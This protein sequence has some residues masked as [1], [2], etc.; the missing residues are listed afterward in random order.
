I[1]RFDEGEVFF[2]E[3]HLLR[4]GAEDK[5]T[6]D[7]SL[8][9]HPEDLIGIPDD[10]LLG[11]KAG[12]LPARRA[13][14]MKGGD[15]LF[16]PDVAGDEMGLSDRDEEFAALSVLENHEFCG[17]ARVIRPFF[18]PEIFSDPIVEMDDD[19]AW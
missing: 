1:L 14:S 12:P 7:C 2:K 3:L 8:C 6:L 4:V 18:D 13:E 16:C 15:L 9:V 5:T 17:L 10:R 11:L 19:I